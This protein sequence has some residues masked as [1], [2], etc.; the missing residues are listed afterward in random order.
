[1]QSAWE[2]GKQGGG[3]APRSLE[4][5]SDGLH[6]AGRS[7]RTAVAY[8]CTGIKGFTEVGMPEWLY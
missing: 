1:M 2:R 3:R 6:C 5:V 8:S 7:V 4:K